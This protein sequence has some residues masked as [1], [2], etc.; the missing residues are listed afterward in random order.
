MKDADRFSFFD[1]GG[2]ANLGL[3]SGTALS[4]VAYQLAFSRKATPCRRAS[5]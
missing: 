1:M 5:N 2:G 3:I 4:S